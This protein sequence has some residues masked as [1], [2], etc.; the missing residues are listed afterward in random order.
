[1]ELCQPSKRENFLIFLSACS[2][3]NTCQN[4]FKLDSF[5]HLW[6]WAQLLM[7]QLP[8]SIKKQHNKRYRRRKNLKNLRKK[9][10]NNPKNKKNKLKTLQ[11]H[12]NLN[13]YH[14][15]Y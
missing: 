12:K 7:A 15:I 9:Y 13:D 10:K 11:F 4:V 14:I 1:M 8:F 2:E 6:K 3:R 5:R